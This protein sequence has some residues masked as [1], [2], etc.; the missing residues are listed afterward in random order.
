MSGVGES[1]G[2]AGGGHDVGVVHE[3]VNGGVG[4]GLGR[5]LIEPGGVQV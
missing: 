5:E 2:V 4:D 3:P 1:D